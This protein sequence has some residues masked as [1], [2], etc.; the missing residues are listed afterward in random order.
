MD[1]FE[2]GEIYLIIDMSLFNFNNVDF[3]RGLS[4]G[5]GN[6]SVYRQWTYNLME[7][8]FKTIFII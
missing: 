3:P 2:T 1:Q 4:D 6:K 7:F 8:K 5:A